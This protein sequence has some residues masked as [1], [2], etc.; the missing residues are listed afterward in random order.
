MSKLK[1]LPISLKSFLTDSVASK[2]VTEPWVALLIPLLAAYRILTLSDIAGALSFN[3]ISTS[4]GP[5]Q[6]K[7]S[8]KEQINKK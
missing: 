2:S 3:N 1:T 8:I 6:E 5:L 4:L 7:V